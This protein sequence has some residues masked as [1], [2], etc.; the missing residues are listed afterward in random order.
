MATDIEA[1]DQLSR[2]MFDRFSSATTAISGT[3]LLLVDDR[4]LDEDDDIFI[5]RQGTVWIDGGQTSGPVADEER[6][7]LSK[8]GNT[9]TMRRAFSVTLPG[10]PINYE[11]HRLFSAERKDE[12]ITVALDLMVPRLWKE[13]IVD[14]TTVTDQF[15][16]DITSHGFHNDLLNE[17]SIVSDGDTEVDFAL[18]AWEIR[19]Q[20]NTAVNLHFLQ[21]IAGSKTIRLRGITAPALADIA[22]PQLQ[23]LTSRAAI[24]LFEGILTSAV[25]DQVTR[26]ER[27]IQNEGRRLAERLAR[28]QLTAPP[29]TIRGEMYDH[30]ILDF[31]FFA[32]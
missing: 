27:S 12:A 16:Y 26:W 30:A 3:N 8:S 14:I 23:I 19:N 6:A 4:L 1:R 22:Q 17:V 25:N 5:T 11:V 9:L 20:G 13:L 21:R 24:Y 28:H 31:N 15:D 2:D 32:T 10:T 18:F 29:G 7:I